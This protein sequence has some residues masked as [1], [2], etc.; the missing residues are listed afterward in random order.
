MSNNAKIDSNDVKTKCQV[1]KCEKVTSFAR[2]ENI[3]NKNGYS[4]NI[5]T[6]LCPMH[7]SHIE[8]ETFENN[9]SIQLRD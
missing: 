4:F 6:A 9:W 8:S 7:S 1:T 3:T 5:V 2:M